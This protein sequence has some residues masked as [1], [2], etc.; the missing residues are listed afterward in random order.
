MYI[1]EIFFL[2]SILKIS[3]KSKNPKFCKNFYFLTY[4]DENPII[5]KLKTGQCVGILSF[6]F[7]TVVSASVNSTEKV[8]KKHLFLFDYCNFSLS[9]R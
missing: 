8:A 2:F 4:K 5:G 9:L 7:L 6:C 1:R 3:F